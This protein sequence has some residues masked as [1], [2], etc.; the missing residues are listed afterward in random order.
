[1]ASN[2]R[3]S[4]RSLFGSKSVI[5]SSIRLAVSASASASDAGFV[6]LGL[7]II[8]SAPEILGADARVG[9]CDLLDLR[10]RFLE[11]RFAMPLERNTPLIGQDRLVELAPSILDQPNDPLEIGQRVFEAHLGDIGGNGV[12]FGHRFYESLGDSMVTTPD[13]TSAYSLAGPRLKHWP[14]GVAGLPRILQAGPA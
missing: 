14:T 12:F 3:A 9:H 8:R 1:M 5:D 6:V 10:L 4:A 2:R 7:S 11:L 13:A